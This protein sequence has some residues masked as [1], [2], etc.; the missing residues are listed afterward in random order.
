MDATAYTRFRSG[1]ICIRAGWY[2]FEGYV[3]GPADPQP[4][5]DEMGI[6]LG[7]GDVFPRI[8]DSWRACYWTP[9]RSTFE[10]AAPPLAAAADA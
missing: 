6:E 8:R 5:L 1:D 4:P 3:V 9:A 2:E 7:V 10:S